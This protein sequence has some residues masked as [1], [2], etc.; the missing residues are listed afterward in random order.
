MAIDGYRVMNSD[1]VEDR[2]VGHARSVRPRTSPLKGYPVI[3]S[4]LFVLDIVSGIIITL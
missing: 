3:A 4:L 1:R 2:K